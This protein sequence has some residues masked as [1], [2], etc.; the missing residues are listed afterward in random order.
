MRIALYV[1]E[2]VSASTINHWLLMAKE[3]LIDEFEVVKAKDITS[4]KLSL[5]NWLIIPGGSGHVICSK[6]SDENRKELEE[7][8]VNG[9]NVMGIC[10]GAYA[11]SSNYDW[12]L[13]LI[14]YQVADK[15]HW[16]RGTGNVDV[17][18]NKATADKLKL[19]NKTVSV[20]YHNGPVF[21]PT[22]IIE[23]H[24]LKSVKVLAKFKSDIVA[25]GGE[26][27]WMMNSPAIVYTKHGKGNIIAISS[28][29][30]KTPIAN[31]IIKKLL[32]LYM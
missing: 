32:K 27:G 28:H 19:K 21:Q 4:I 6:L 23:K 16:K 2:G 31:K 30:E 1:D 5:F 18:F 26:S 12:S 22:L 9:L 13:D 8:I 25:E 29:F 15:P 3:G 20:H 7:T 14:P 10:A 17:E 11:L 24:V